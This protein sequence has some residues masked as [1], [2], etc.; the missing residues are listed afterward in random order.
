MRQGCRGDLRS[1]FT[2]VETEAPGGLMGSTQQQ[3]RSFETIVSEEAFP[4]CSS[5]SFYVRVSIL[6]HN[7]SYYLLRTF[8]MLDAMISVNSILSSQKPLDVGVY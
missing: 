4:L 7:N 6:T 5:L 8:Y 1:I 2:D 3:K